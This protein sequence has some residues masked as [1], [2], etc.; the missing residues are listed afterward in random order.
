MSEA[1]REA[2][3]T[4]LAALPDVVRA[5]TWGERAFFPT[6]H[7]VYAW[8]GWAATLSPAAA[9][10]HDLPAPIEAAHDKA[11]AAARRRLAAA[12]RAPKAWMAGGP[13]RPAGAG[14][15]RPGHPA[16]RQGRRAALPSP[17]CSRH[18]SSP[19]ST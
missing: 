4:R 3:E 7:P 13:V 18:A 15:G 8:M 9:D 2:I 14:S 10:A 6:P 1:V 5:T 19:A 11:L 16:S 12:R 17:T